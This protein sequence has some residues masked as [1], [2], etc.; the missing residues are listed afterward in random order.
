MTD[1][2]HG[3]HD[4]HDGHDGYGSHDGETDNNIHQTGSPCILCSPL[5]S[6]W[7]SNK[8][9]PTAFKVFTFQ[10]AFFLYLSLLSV[11]IFTFCIFLYMFFLLCREKPQCANS[12]KVALCLAVPDLYLGY[13]SLTF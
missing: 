10:V 2:D 3:D 8:S 12:P 4:D 9:L 7:R 5:P 6:H 1:D 11:F 13:P